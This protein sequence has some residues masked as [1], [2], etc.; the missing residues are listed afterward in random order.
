MLSAVCA[1][2]TDFL[3]HVFLY[4]GIDPCT[5]FFIRAPMLSSKME[6]GA[7][8]VSSL[9]SCPHHLLPSLA[10]PSHI[11]PAATQQCPAAAFTHSPSGNATVPSSC[12]PN[13]SLC[14][15]VLITLWRSSGTARPLHLSSTPCSS[16]LLLPS[17]GEASSS[18]QQQL[19]LHQPRTQPTPAAA[20]YVRRYA[21]SLGE[22][23]VRRVQNGGDER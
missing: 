15:H 5:C 23:E 6:F 9:C 4:T 11:L 2:T 17:D 13:T 8:L 7:L 22:R 1:R 10:M 14:C 12:S 20:G 19:R 3:V 16:S 18:L 21:G